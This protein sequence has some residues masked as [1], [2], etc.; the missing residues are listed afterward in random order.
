MKDARRATL[1]SSFALAHDDSSPSQGEPK[2]CS[3]PN[4]PCRLPPL[5]KGSQSN[6]PGRMPQTES[7]CRMHPAQCLPLTRGAKAMPLIE[8]PRPNASPLQGEPKQCRRPKAP[9]RK[10]PAECTQPNAS[11][12]LR[13]G[14]ASGEAASDGR[15]RREKRR[16][17]LRGET[18]IENT[19]SGKLRAVLFVMPNSMLTLPRSYRTR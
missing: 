18:N 10:Q 13:G 9:D 17:G 15:V 12:C 3:R 8:C 7:A 1:Q 2:Q 4:A 16:K 19:R 5:G 14:G 6:A 11:P